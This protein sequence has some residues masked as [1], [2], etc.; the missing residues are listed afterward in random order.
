MFKDLVSST[1]LEFQWLSGFADS[2]VS[3]D[4]WFDSAWVLARVFSTVGVKE[5]NP[6]EGSCCGK[7]ALTHPDHYVTHPYRA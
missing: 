5:I 3:D 2:F 6:A 1:H 7:M 4:G